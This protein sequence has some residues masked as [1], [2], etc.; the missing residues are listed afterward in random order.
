MNDIRPWQHLVHGKGAWGDMRLQEE[1]H[2]RWGGPS[3]RIAVRAVRVS[4][5]ATHDS[6]G[7]RSMSFHLSVDGTIASSFCTLPGAVSARHKE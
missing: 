1:Q 4:G 7:A 6:S 3:W 2:V 5:H